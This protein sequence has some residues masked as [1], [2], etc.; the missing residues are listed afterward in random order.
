MY[1]D[2]KDIED[3]QKRGEY[4][5]QEYIPTSSIFSR[6]RVSKYEQEISFIYANLTFEELSEA[7]ENLKEFDEQFNLE[8]VNR[9]ATTLYNNLHYKDVFIDDKDLE[10]LMRQV[11]EN[12]LNYYILSSRTMNIASDT[13]EY[14]GKAILLKEGLDWKDIKHKGHNLYEIYELIKEKYKEAFSS[15]TE[16]DI[17][18]LQKMSS[19][20]S[21]NKINITSRYPGEQFVKGDLSVLL[22]LANSFFKASLSAGNKC[23]MELIS[24]EKNNNLEITEELFNKN[25]NEINYLNTDLMVEEIA[26]LISKYS[27][28]YIFTTKPKDEFDRINIYTLRSKI[29]KKSCDV[30]EHFSN[31]F[32]IDEDKTL[33]ELRESGHNVKN[34]YYSLDYKTRL[35]LILETLFKYDELSDKEKVLES[36]LCSNVIDEDIKQS[37]RD[38]Y[39]DKDRVLNIKPSQIKTIVDNYNLKI[40]NL[41]RK[42]IEKAMDKLFTMNIT[43]RLNI[44]TRFPGKYYI[45]ENVSFILNLAYAISTESLDKRKQKVKK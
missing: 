6:Y 20:D 8:E 4:K 33:E 19:K 42:K 10:K 37:L 7:V 29:I 27:Y 11:E 21:S 44:M 12:M 1:L 32:L 24:Y 36:L 43:D 41:D 26:T 16:E 17:L 5:K 28:E 35:S 31:A 30:F 14:L 18:S 45:T 39:L 23:A 15:L 2:I 22:K 34:K 25:K 9:K 40:D 38:N 13:C 3:K